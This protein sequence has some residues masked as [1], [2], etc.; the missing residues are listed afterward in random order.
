[1]S[2]LLSLLTQRDD[3]LARRDTDELLRLNDLTRPYG[4]SLTHED[5]VALLK[6]RAEALKNSS[7]IEVGP[8]ILEKLGEA[9]CDSAYINGQNYADTLCALTELFYY[10]KNDT[11][12]SLPDDDLIG[13]MKQCFDDDCEGSLELLAGRDME[14]MAR[15]VRAYGRIEVPPETDGLAAGQGGGYE[16][17]EDEQ[18]RT[19]RF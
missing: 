3:T 4:L 8:G 15:N 16:V 7:R 13:V 1:M 6:V 17:E 2:G 10:L 9:F 18:W 19:V 14:A 12:D 5:A 11:L